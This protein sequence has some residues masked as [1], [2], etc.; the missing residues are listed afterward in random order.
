MR[1]NNSVGENMS[2]P[3]QCP[4]MEEIATFIDGGLTAEARGEIL[5]HLDGCETCYAVFTDTVRFL[6]A[7]KKPE[8]LPRP[9]WHISPAA[10]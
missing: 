7:D 10:R 5:E 4:K 3:N 2:V 9:R 1:D 8:Q 6:E